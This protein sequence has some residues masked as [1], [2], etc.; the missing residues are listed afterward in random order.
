MLK[1]K[2]NFGYTIIEVLVVIS[3]V[4]F[5][6]SAAMYTLSYT[7]AKARDVKRVAD[8]EQIRKAIEIFKNENGR[9]PGMTSAGAKTDG[10]NDEGECVG[11]QDSN[12]TDISGITRCG[13]SSVFEYV[14]RD[15][16]KDIPADPSHN[17]NRYQISGTNM[18]PA[19]AYFYS[20]DI[21][22]QCAGSNPPQYK[23]AALCLHHS[24]S[25]LHSCA[26]NN[27]EC[28]LN[29]NMDQDGSDYCVIFGPM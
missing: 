16:I 20:Y 2:Q 7:R 5:L 22:R 8:I 11:D 24:E 18:P 14:M 25:G 6:V 26:E 29:G 27:P 19:E 9:Y 13:W 3:I 10:M 12:G 21:Q 17:Y 4:G 28:G 1:N 15:Y 23:C